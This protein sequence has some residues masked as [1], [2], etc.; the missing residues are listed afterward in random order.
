M[1]P[2]TLAGGLLAGLLLASAVGRAPAQS[3]VAAEIG[4][5]ETVDPASGRRLLHVL[6]GLGHAEVRAV[7]REL[8]RAGF[9]VSWQA[10]ALDAFT[11][12][13]LQR[14]QTQRGLAVCACVTI[15]TLIELGIPTRIVQTI[16]LEAAPLPEV[17]PGA[18]A[19]GGAPEEAI[20]GYVGYDSYYPYGGAYLV[21]FIPHPHDPHGQPTF[22]PGGHARA[23]RVPAAGRSPAMMPRPAPF[24]RVSAPPNVVR[25]S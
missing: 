9:E 4:V 18:R 24:P 17:A 8:A 10:G 3:A 11:R 13:A 16:V 19:G 20:P 22:H 7:Q 21:P 1:T 6:E 25:G 14:F 23:G 2:S 15:E 5:I 12:G